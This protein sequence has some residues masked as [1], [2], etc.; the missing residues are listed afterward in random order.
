MKL[1]PP[2]NHAQN[3]DWS[4]QY[5]VAYLVGILPAVLLLTYLTLS[6]NSPQDV[7]VYYKEL[8]TIHTTTT[9]IMKFISDY[10]N[11]MFYSFYIYFFY[12][13]IKTKDKRL[14]SITLYYI[15]FQIVIGVLLV[16]FLKISIGRP[17][18][19]I[20][21]SFMPFSFNSYYH[22]AVSGHVTEISGSALTLSMIYR[23]MFYSF[24]FGLC[25]ATMAYSRIYLGQ[26]HISDTWA[27][28]FFGSLSAVLI[29]L[30]WNKR[31][32][33]NG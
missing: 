3:S 19:N 5:S 28:L 26:H 4:K 29:V 30:F 15:F 1:C 16:H 9:K 2:L 18:P 13:G 10:G 12:L 23:N 14:W 21:G 33:K 22:S 32:L 17:R 31:S 24:I 11:M 8:R 20:E 27:G 7:A 6:F 25:I